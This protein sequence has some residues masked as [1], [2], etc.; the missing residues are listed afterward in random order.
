MSISQSNGTKLLI[1]P[2]APREPGN[3]SATPAHHVFLDNTK[4]SKVSNSKPVLTDLWT[5]PA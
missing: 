3:V 1:I 2:A 4:G 5:P